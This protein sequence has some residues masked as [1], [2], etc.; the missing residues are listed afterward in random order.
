MTKVLLSIKPEFANKIFDGTKKYEFRKILFKRAGISSILVYVSSPVQRIIGEFTI[1]A[2]ISGTLTAV[3]EI[4]ENSAG[5]SESYFR[6]Y[7]SDKT[8]A[9]AIKIGQVKKFKHAKTLAQYSIKHA[10]QSF[11]YVED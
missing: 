11:V 1:D 6:S 7:F 10:P 2:I 5:I 4:T 8:I 9:H 3:W